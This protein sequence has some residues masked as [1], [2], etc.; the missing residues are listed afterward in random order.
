MRSSLVKVDYRW[1]KA[2][3]TQHV[4]LDHAKS[5]KEVHPSQTVS[6]TASFCHNHV[7]VSTCTPPNLPAWHSHTGMCCPAVN[8]SC[9]LQLRQYHIA[10][11]ITSATKPHC[12]LQHIAVKPCQD[13]AQRI[14]THHTYN[15]PVAKPASLNSRLHLCQWL[16]LMTMSAC[17][18]CSQRACS[19]VPIALQLDKRHA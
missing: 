3:Q 7:D 14:H 13:L 16:H 5:E 6:Q 19:S 10:D 2:S 18:C 17:A 4:A 11:I 1:A 8:H 9:P 15:K 12:V